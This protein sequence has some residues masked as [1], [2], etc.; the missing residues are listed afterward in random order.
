MIIGQYCPM[1]IQ[2]FQKKLLEAQNME[3]ITKKKIARAFQTV[4]VQQGFDHT[5]VKAIMHH[6]HLRR[7]TFYVYFRDKFELLVWF[8]NDRMS[9]TIE[10]NINYLQWPEIIKITCYELDANREFYKECFKNQNEIDITAIIANHF[11]FLFTHLVKCESIKFLSEDKT[12]IW[13]LCLGITHSIVHNITTNHPEDYEQLAKD[14]IISI[15]ISLKNLK[16]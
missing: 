8:I 14:A 5:S 4:V 11:A 3:Y 2:L 16:N 9:E 10:S 12:L 15:N 1:H 6:A 7:Q 13:L